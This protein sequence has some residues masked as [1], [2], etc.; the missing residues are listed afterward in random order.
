M[1]NFNDVLIDYFDQKGKLSSKLRDD[2]NDLDSLDDEFNFILNKYKTITDFAINTFKPIYL[3]SR[4]LRRVG[5]ITISPEQRREIVSKLSEDNTK[6][7]VDIIMR[8][9]FVK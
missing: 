8:N 9:L 3:L 7:E 6:E 1:S 4:E 5:K 2:I